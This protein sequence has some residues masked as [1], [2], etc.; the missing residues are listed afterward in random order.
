MENQES[1]NKMRLLVISDTHIPDRYDVLPGAVLK[2]LKKIDLIIHAG[3]F[4]SIEY[5][6]ELKKIK[7]LKAALGNLDTPEL[8]KFLKPKESFSLGKF[9]IGIMHGLG[10]PDGVLDLVKKEFDNTYDLVVFGHTHQP[11]IESIGKTIFLNPGSPTDKI[12]APV[13]AYAIVDI[14]DTLKTEI[15][16]L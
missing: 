1:S 6:K 14:G 9:K 15:I 4:T 7:P 11:A 10:K 16:K 2:E 12:F 5:Y 8:S 3:D 13:N